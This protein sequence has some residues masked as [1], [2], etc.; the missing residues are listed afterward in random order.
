MRRAL[1]DRLWEKVEKH[2]EDCVCC[3]G[4]WIWTGGRHENGYGRFWDGSAVVPSHRVV[5]ELLV[6]SIPDGFHLDHLCR[7]PPCVNPEH[8]EPVTRLENLRRGIHVNR[9]KT[10]CPAGHA[11][12]DLNTYIENGRRHCR[13][14]VREAGRRYYRRKLLAA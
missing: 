2:D 8:L 1:E 3:D 4:C 5:Y 9:E 12:D 13:I 11:Y 14:C 7:R 10:H 6:G